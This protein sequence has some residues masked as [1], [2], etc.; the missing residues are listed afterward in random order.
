MV[1]ISSPFRREEI[2]RR[3]GGRLGGFLMRSGSPEDKIAEYA[4][5]LAKH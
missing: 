5:F 1:L 3:T 2:K 4:A